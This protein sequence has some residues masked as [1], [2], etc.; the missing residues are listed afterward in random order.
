MVG[1]ERVGIGR[2]DDRRVEEWIVVVKGDEG[3]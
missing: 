2:S 1:W 3:V